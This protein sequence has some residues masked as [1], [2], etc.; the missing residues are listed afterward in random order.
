MRGRFLT[1][2]AEHGQRDAVPPVAGEGWNLEAFRQHI[3]GK[4]CVH[5]W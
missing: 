1:T 2:L 3:A 5:A 4:G